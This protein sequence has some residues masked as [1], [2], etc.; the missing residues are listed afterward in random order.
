MTDLEDRIREAL[1]DPRRDLPAW[2]DPVPRIRH[3]A[4]RQQAAVLAAGVAIALAFATPLAVLWW[5]TSRPTRL[6]FHPPVARRTPSPP[7]S[8]LFAGGAA[9][10]PVPLWAKRLRG[11]VAYTC[12]ES[13]CLMHADGR[14]SRVLAATFPR[15]DPAWSQDGRHLSFRGYYGNG[16]G[17]YDLYAADLK[18]CRLT[19]LTH[20]MNGASSSW[21]PDEHQIAFSVPFGMYVINPKGTGLRQLI[22]SSTRYSYGADM[23][24]WSSV[25]DRIAYTFLLPPHGRPEIYVIKPDGTGNTLL[26]YGA[27]GYDQPAWSPD[28]R[29]I[30][31]T[32]NPYAAS[33][34]IVASA[35][36]TGAHRISPAR[37]TSYSPTWT[38]GGKVV[39]LRQT[40]S[41]TQTT[42]AP[43]SAYIV[44]PDGTGL[45]LLY[46]NL[47]ASQIAWGPA[48]LP[49]SLC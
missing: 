6:P 15:D 8:S 44:N 3:A 32:A 25:S 43:T 47:D 33:S 5:P 34:I 12:G 16:D 45:R 7:R 28:G 20:Q 19:R 30:A 10:R 42:G 14:V 23:P 39:F 27:P 37:W 41:P 24:A 4:R 29:L 36:G 9:F 2:P 13:L 40:G 22:K 18:G 35:D 38:P 21:S 26:T 49:A 17:Q 48:T 1:K 31:Y 11:E 46:R